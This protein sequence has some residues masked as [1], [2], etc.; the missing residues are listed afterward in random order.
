[1]NCQGAREYFSEPLDSHIGLTERVPLEAHLRECEACQ[2]E[3]EALRLSEPPRIAA[4]RPG[5][6]LDFFSKALDGLRLADM[7]DR[8]R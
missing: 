6:K 4:W 8:L 7:V 5:F 1:M 3:L 2:Q